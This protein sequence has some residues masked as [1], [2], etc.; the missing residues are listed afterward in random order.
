[1]CSKDGEAPLSAKSTCENFHKSRLDV[2]TKNAER[3]GVGLFITEFGACA[4]TEAC[5]M[6]ITAATDAIDDHLVSWAYW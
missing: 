1:M 4:N 5:V 2:R 6:E 3:L